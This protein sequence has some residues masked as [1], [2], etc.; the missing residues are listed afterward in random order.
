MKNSRFKFRAWNKKKKK[1]ED[2]AGIALDIE[3]G[4]PWWTEFGEMMVEAEDVILMQCTGIIDRNGKEIYEGDIVKVPIE[5]IEE[6]GASPVEFIEAIAQVVYKPGSFYID[7]SSR[8]L[9]I[10][11]SCEVIGNIYDGIKE[12]ND[13]TA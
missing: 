4:M 6:I 8:M 13:G 11:S 9:E 3:K 5:L 10:N 1:W 12:E 7:L 2:P